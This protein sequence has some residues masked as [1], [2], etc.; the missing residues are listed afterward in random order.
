MKSPLP[1]V[2]A[3]L[4]LLLSACAST[5]NVLD[6]VERGQTEAQAT[7]AVRATPAWTF[8]NDKTKYIVYGFIATFLDMYDNTITYY[9]IKLER[10]KVVDKG[11]MSKRQREEIKMLDPGFDTDQLIRQPAKPDQAAIAREHATHS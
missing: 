10:G 11:M 5:L 1:I 9:Y 7:A 8:E 2:I 3:S 4:A 6:D